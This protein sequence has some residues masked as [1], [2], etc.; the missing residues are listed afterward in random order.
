ML[1]G[2]VV[3]I[4][5]LSL[6]GCSAPKNQ[7]FV[8]IKGG[9]YNNKTQSQNNS[10]I[11][12]LLWSKHKTTVRE[13]YK[14]VESD[15]KD[16]DA[17]K[18][19]SWSGDSESD[20]IANPDWPMTGINWFEAINYCN[21]LSLQEG[22]TP[23]YKVSGAIPFFPGSRE[24]MPDAPTVIMDIA[25]NGYRLPLSVEWEYAAKGGKRGIRTMWWEKIDFLKI[26]FFAENSEA[27]LHKIGEKLANPAGLYDIVGLAEE[28]CWDDKTGV[29]NEEPSDSSKICRGGSYVDSGT[30]AYPKVAD[31][32]V[33]ERIGRPV[34]FSEYRTAPALS[35]AAGIRIV[36]K[37]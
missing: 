27:H 7:R 29:Q 30:K 12:D 2:V 4:M 23:V 21:W 14:Y 11:S 13:W 19:V 16:F 28:W 36:R 34:F 5:A 18:I 9:I 25:E 26:G 6:A 20:Y 10:Q 33:E 8:L 1:K 17:K 3:F 35:R 37:P 22:L 31:G 15:Y 24:S 32:Q